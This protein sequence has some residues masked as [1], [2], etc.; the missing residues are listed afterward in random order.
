MK[1]IPIILSS[2]DLYEDA[3]NPFFRLLQAN[4]HNASKDVYLITESK[5][6]IDSYFNVQCINYPS[7][8]WSDRVIFALSK[9]HAEFA[10]FFL[11]DF[12]LEREVNEEIIKSAEECI[13]TDSNVGVIKFIP[14]ITSSWYNDKVF[15]DTYF[16]EIPYSSKHRSNLMLSLYRISYFSQMLRHKETPWDFEAFGTY[17]S[18]RLKEKVLIQND[19]FPLAFPYNYQIKYGFGISKKK[20]LRNNQKLFEQYGI[21]VDFEKLGWYEEV[22]APKII[23]LKR[24]FLQKCIMPV[25]N[26]KLFFT[27]MSVIIKEWYYKISH[28]HHYF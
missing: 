3:W 5:K 10:W 18:R 28:L 12:F 8:Y 26:P 9:I 22:A 17:R 1:E 13:V 16:S 7:S 25:I 21:N 23:G 14:C 15:I 24:T 19:S 20:W 27:I 11:E 2:C 6:Y 4:W